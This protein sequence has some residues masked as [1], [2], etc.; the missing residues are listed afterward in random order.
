MFSR[1][2][3]ASSTASLS[4][5]LGYPTS[6]EEVEIMERFQEENPLETLKPVTDEGTIIQI[7]GTV[8]KIFASEKL[9]QY[10][11][12]IAAKT[13]AGRYFKLGSSTRASSLAAFLT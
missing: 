4:F 13:R 2:L 10:I 3:K 8:R 6:A 9:K 1:F 11:A 12:A 7:R 5:S